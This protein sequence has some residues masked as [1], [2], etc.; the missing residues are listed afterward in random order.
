MEMIKLN[1]RTGKNMLC[2]TWTMFLTKDDKYF[3]NPFEP[4]EPLYRCLFVKAGEL[5]ETFAIYFH[6][7]ETETAPPLEPP[8]YFY[9]AF[10]QMTV[11]Q[12]RSSGTIREMDIFEKAEYLELMPARLA[13]KKNSIGLPITISEEEQ[14]KTLEMLKSGEFYR[15]EPLD[16]YYK[17]YERG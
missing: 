7:H 2:L 9:G 13:G 4:K 14:K 10:N 6:V 5:S 16:F 1:K 15:F 3:A 17:T 12:M 11:Y 8:I